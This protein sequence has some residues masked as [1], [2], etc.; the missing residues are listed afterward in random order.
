MCILYICQESYQTSFMLSSDYLFFFIYMFII[1][2]NYKDRILF[3]E[4]RKVD[5]FAGEKRSQRLHVDYTSIF[6]V[7]NLRGN[8]TKKKENK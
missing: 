4:V 7:P 1:S 2:R 8:V 3:V 5:E 6:K